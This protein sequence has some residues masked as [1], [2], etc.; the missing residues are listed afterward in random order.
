M[1]PAITALTAAILSL[2]YVKLL[3][4]VV[5]QRHKH[6]IGLGHGVETE[7]DNSL[8]KA[9]RIHGNFSENIPLCLILLALIELA[10]IHQ[11]IC[12]VLGATLIIGRFLHYKGISKSIG[13]SKGR[14]WGMMLTVV[15]YFVA[16]I[17][18]IGLSIKHLIG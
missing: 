5:K 3:A 12:A 4:N 15:Y 11:I 13:T 7:K 2:I 9:I 14:Y 10:G 16:A 1:Y 18:L 17:L 6:K 8:I